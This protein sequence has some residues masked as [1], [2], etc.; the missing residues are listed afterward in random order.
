M[1]KYE[2]LEVWKKSIL[3]V[4]KIYK[5]SQENSKLSHDYGLLDQIR[6]AAVSIPSNI[7]EGN[8]RETTTEFIRYLV[9]ARGSTAELSTQL[10]I[11]KDIG[12]ISDEEYIIL[13][14]SIIEIHKMINGLISFQKQKRATLVPSS[15]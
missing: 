8:E 12:Y 7:A 10:L 1:S 13:S 9:I 15:N 11:C 2:N 14:E 3:L 4:T 6:R 5:F